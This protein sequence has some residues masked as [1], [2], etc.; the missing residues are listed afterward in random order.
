MNILV[1]GASGPTGR[2][3]V[4]QALARGH[5]VNAFVREPKRLAITHPSLRVATGDALDADAVM[6]AVAGHDA[7]ISALGAPANKTGVIRSQGTLNIVRAM[8]AHGVRRLV[9]LASL[10]Y[11]DSEAVLTRTP[12][13]FRY[14]IAPILLREGFADHALQESHIKSSDLDWVIVRPGN[15]TNGPLTRRYRHG[16]A[17]TDRSI[18]VEVSRADVADFMLNQLSDDTYLRQTPGVSD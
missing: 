16:F 11:G 13:L 9:S 17:A 8:Q 1:F 15:L 7:V 3:V 4:E 18:K 2:Q 5:A 6:A 10:G 14:I 12:F